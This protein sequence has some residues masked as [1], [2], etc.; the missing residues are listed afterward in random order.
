MEKVRTA[1]RN[2]RAFEEGAE[3]VQRLES[4]VGDRRATCHG[5]GSELACE[6]HR[7]S[8]REEVVLEG[9]QLCSRDMRYLENIVDIIGQ[10]PRRGHNHTHFEEVPRPEVLRQGLGYGCLQLVRHL[11]IVLVGGGISVWGRGLLLRVLHLS[12]GEVPE[13]GWGN[14]GVAGAPAGD[15]AGCSRA[16]VL[17]YALQQG[18]ALHQRKRDVFKNADIRCPPRR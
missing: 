1:D 9:N 3:L 10:R 11:R 14:G 12:N 2:D 18:T 7:G 13:P 8:P 15:Q 6:A 17:G 16:R 4:L 5:R